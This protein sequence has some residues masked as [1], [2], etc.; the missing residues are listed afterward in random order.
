MTNEKKRYLNGYVEF[1]Q[2]L[3]VDNDLFIFT[4]VFRCGG[5]ARGKRRWEDEYRRQVLDRFRKRLD[6][7]GRYGEHPITFEDFWIHEFDTCSKTRIVLPHP[8]HHVHALLPIRKEQVYR[9]WDYSTQEA[10]PKL[11][12]SLNVMQRTVSSW[13]LE[14][15]KDDQ[16]V[17]WVNYMHKSPDSYRW[18]RAC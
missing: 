10:D 3:K 16:L 7:R 18:T 2:D 1:F 12:K 15:V 14:P 11:A 13:H 4:V 8:V 9:I 5:R 17:K 6:P